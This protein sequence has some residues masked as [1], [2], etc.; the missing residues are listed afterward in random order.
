MLSNIKTEAN[1]NEIIVNFN[2]AIKRGW[3]HFDNA[4]ICCL[5]FLDKLNVENVAL[6]GFDGFK[7]KYNESYSDSYLPT[8]NPDNKWEELNNEIED[9]FH[10]VQMTMGSKMH[11]SFVTDSIFDDKNK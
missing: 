5:R 1:K 3:E 11:I 9:M 6:A 2:H 8:L 10:D 7:T 4:V